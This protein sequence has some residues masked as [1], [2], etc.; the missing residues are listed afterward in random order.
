MSLGFFD[1]LRQTFPSA[2]IHV[3][4]KDGLADLVAFNFGVHAI[5]RFNSAKNRGLI[6]AAAFGRVV[7]RH[8]PF[9][10]FYCLPNSFSSAVMGFFTGSRIRIGYR[11][12]GRSLLLTKT[13]RRPANVHRAEEY[14]ALVD[15]DAGRSPRTVSVCLPLNG[16]ETGVLPKSQP[17]T[18]WVALN[19]NSEAPSRRM[20]K[21]KWAEIARQMLVREDC[22]IVLIGSPKEAAGCAELA[23]MIGMPVRVMD[24]SGQTDLPQLA[25]LLKSCALL[26]TTDSG[27]AHLANAV[28]TPTVVL[29]GAGDDQK[30]APY[31]KE[32]LSVIRLDGLD[33]APCVLN[34]CTFGDQRCLERISVDQIVQ[35]AES[36]IQ[37]EP[38]SA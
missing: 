23:A 6:G 10:R 9:D 24:V 36:T 18:Y 26:I 16:A 20:S 25:R 31:R 2:E 22:R 12:E 7:A 14:A 21:Q 35:T 15:P 37:A 33:C 32:R 3:I 29:F 34:V 28:G 19:C 5:H 4:V 38:K 17:G 27:P 30:T 8:G 11:N 13:L 1:R